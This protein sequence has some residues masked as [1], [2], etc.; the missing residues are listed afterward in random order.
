MSFTMPQSRALCCAARYRPEA[1][2]DMCDY[3]GEHVLENIRDQYEYTAQRDLMPHPEHPSHVAAA[4]KA[5][6]DAVR[7]YLQAHVVDVS[8]HES[9]I[10]CTDPT[11]GRCEDNGAPICEGC[12]EI[13]FNR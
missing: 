3:I 12:A 7:I 8:D 4:E 2:Y 1:S 10:R 13:Y 9:C 6:L 5:L 11:N